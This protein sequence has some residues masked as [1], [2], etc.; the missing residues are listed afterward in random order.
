MSQ[1]P[2]KG[3]KTLEDF[4]RY[5]LSRMQAAETAQGQGTVDAL[6]DAWWLVGGALSLEP[7]QWR[8]FAH[9]RLSREERRRVCELLRQR[10]EQHVPV[11]YLLGEAWFAGLK[12]KVTPAVLIPRSP[13][14][15]LI[16]QGF[17]PWLRQPPKRVLDLCTGSGC[18]GIATALAFP[19]ADVDL[20]DLSSE[21]L[22]VAEENLRAYGLEGRVRTVCS[23]AF[24]ALQGHYDL[25]LCNPPYVGAEEMASLPAEFRHEPAEALASGDDGMDLPLRILHDAPDYLEAEGLLFL[26]VGYSQPVLEQ[27][28]PELP[29]VWIAL[30]NGGSGIAVIQREELLAGRPAIAAALR[31]R[32]E[33]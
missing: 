20:A 7:E 30:E 33:H 8:A 22:A 10:V 4:V 11:A 31:T 6:D 1:Q 29:L 17:A 21:A 18:I 13:F 9:A 23:N 16:G 24:S 2:C 19:E 5:A 15:E 28:L 27:L 26:E 32:E 14:A 25:I 12:F 3:L